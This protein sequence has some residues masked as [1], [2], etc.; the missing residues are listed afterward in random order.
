MSNRFVHL[1]VHSEYSILDA[2]CKIPDLVAMAAKCEMNALALTDHGVLSGA[3]KFYQQAKKS[4]IKPI[5]GS[6]VYV[7]PKDRF[8]KTPTAGQ[9]YYHLVLLAENEAGYRNLL[10]LVSL[11]YS[12]GFY[13]RPRVDK[14]LLSRYSKGLIALSGCESG[15]IPKLLSIGRKEEA[16]HAADELN[17]IFG[18]NNF[19]IELQDHGLD[20]HRC[21]SESLRQL[22]DELS[23]PLV[24]TNDIH[25]ISPNDRLAHEVLLNIYANKK[26]TDEDRRR[27]DGDGYHFRTFAEMARLFPDIPQALSQTQEIADRCQIEIEFGAPQIP[28]FEFPQ[29][30][31]TADDYLRELTLSGALNRFNTI[32]PEIRKRLE[33]ELSVIAQMNYATYFLIVWDFVRFAHERQV[34]VGPGRGSATGSL[35]AYCLGIT[36]VDP[37]RY[38]L[39]FERFLN[40][41]RIGLPDFDID[42]CAKGRDKV[43]SY[44][45]EKYGQ[46]R[47]AQIVTFDRM[48]ARS[49]IRDV[50][51]VLA[52]PYDKTN[53]IA[54]LVPFGY[55]LD[56]AFSQVAEL[57][58]LLETDAEVV[59]M[60]QIGRCLE[61]QI[62]NV[63]T[64]AAGVVIAT[65]DLLDHTPVQR[66][67]D[68]EIVT[69]YD[70]DDLE[71]IGLL[72]MDFLG[73]R[74][75]TLIAETIRTVAER[76]GRVLDIERLPLDDEKTYAL[77]RTCRTGGIFQLESSGMKGLIQRMHPSQFEDLI[78]L[79]ALYR[80]G[81]LES[82]MVD[83]YI[84]R[85][86]GSQRVEYIHPSV[87]AVL[88]ETYGLPIYQEQLLL[89]AQNLAGFSLGEADILRKAMGKKK[90]AIMASMSDKFFRGCATNKIDQKI[91]LQAF[92]DMEKFSRYGFNKSH[93]TAYAFVSYWTAYLKANYPAYFLASLLTSV[94]GDSDKVAE[95]INECAEMKIKV[96]PPDI[97]ESERDFTPIDDHTIRFGLGAIKHV[98]DSAITAIITAR[99]E[100]KRFSSF[101]DLCQSLNEE[102]ISREILASLIQVGVFDQFGQSRKGLLQCVST[103]MEI[104]HSA[105]KERSTGQRSLFADKTEIY[106]QDAFTVDTEEF[107][108]EEILQI[109]KELLGL[110]LTAHPLD[111]HKDILTTCC[112]PAADLAA[113][114]E[115]ERVTI[116]GRIKR[117]QKI[118]TKK[119]DQMAFVTIEDLSGE[120]EVTI[121]PKLLEKKNG[122][123]KEEELLALE[124]SIGKRNGEMSLIAERIISLAE[125]RQQTP[126]AIY[127]TLKAEEIEKQR[128]RAIIDVV[129]THPGPL[130]LIIRLTNDDHAIEILADKSYM[131]TPCA[132]LMQKLENICGKETIMVRQ[133]RIAKV[134]LQ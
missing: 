1:H 8:D 46:K 9:R 128:L 108:P 100:K 99:K 74:N 72:K 98:S 75:L 2:T 130:P 102:A 23:L 31:K 28:P 13:Y 4:G 42:F 95:Y 16:Y 79:L 78:A 92:T 77:I 6:E 22:A 73:L 32:T 5:I 101:F 124:V 117:V 118:N 37:I 94:A 131:V 30:Y 107:L 19:F 60:V 127:L 129:E 48:A 112:I 87:E 93:A 7:A 105:Q 125:L 64:H 34:P 133:N 71:V 20:S 88:A 91:A 27:F 67:S 25:Y 115:G 103:G 11:A 111:K 69:Q 24:V 59:E 126:L 14:E 82:G 110:Y 33:Y 52:I 132:A 89:I 80:P 97:N 40:P 65:E 63:S 10:R 114:P 122:S 119:G 51:R 70:M 26:I 21:Q 41:E 18:R 43:I 90:Q 121:F 109:E 76:T 29:A 17:S 66:I 49:V 86:R 54:K 57:K 96:L 44:V 134:D 123:V 55:S 61:G 68:D 12:E 83:D 106:S 104:M 36:S 45:K 120:V 116:G 62:R 35:V 38:N 85:R 56:R 58:S 15:E 39:I 3:I 81:P 53:Q 84:A 113:L 47:M 50:G